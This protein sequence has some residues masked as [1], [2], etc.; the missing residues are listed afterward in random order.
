MDGPTGGGPRRLRAVAE[1]GAPAPEALQDAILACLAAAPG[2][3]AP[4]A[5]APALAERL[6]IAAA[7]LP[8]RDVQVALGV[9]VATG[10]VDEAAGRLVP[11]EQERRR[12]G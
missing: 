12:A 11:V 6:G 9:L 8:A 5:L 7:A 4:R 3:L 10:R 1:G 2:G